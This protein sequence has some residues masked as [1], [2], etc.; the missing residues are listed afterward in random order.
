MSQYHLMLADDIDE[1]LAT[2]DPATQAEIREWARRL[3]AMI[4]TAEPYG[5]FALSLVAADWTR[6]SSAEG[7][8][9]D[10]NV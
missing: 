9:G 1:K 3:R 4:D 7:K 5:W 6:E 10:G 8:S 2:L